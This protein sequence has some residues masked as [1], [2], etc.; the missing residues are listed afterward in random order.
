MRSLVLWSGYR[1]RVADD[2]RGTS[3]LRVGEPFLPVV[4]AAAALLALVVA[5][6]LLLGPGAARFDVGMA[7]DAPQ[8]V[9]AGSAIPVLPAPDRD[10]RAEAAAQEQAARA[11]ALAGATALVADRTAAVAARDATSWVDS[12]SDAATAAAEFAALVS[13]PVTA[14]EIRVVEEAVERDR[15]V[16]TGVGPGTWRGRAVTTYQLGSSLA[17]RR[18]DSFSLLPD[19]DGGWRLSGW[20]ASPQDGAT[21]P[22]QLGPV[23]HVEGPRAVVLSWPTAQEQTDTPGDLAAATE[24]A[25]QAASWTA[26]G[27]ELVDGV[28]GKDWPRT[29]LMLVPGTGSQ[30]SA[31]VPGEQP[32]VDNVYAAVTADTVT[33]SGTGD[34]V[35][36]NPAARSE[37][38][39]ETWQVTVTH[40]LV[41]VASGAVHGDGQPLWLSEG[42]ADL[43]GWSEVIDEPAERDLVAGRLLDRVL[44]GDG[45][46]SLAGQPEFTATDPEVVG[47]AYDGSWLAVLL[48]QDRLGRDGLMDLYAATSSGDGAPVD[49]APDDRTPEDR[50]PE[51]RF[52]AEL[53]A[54]A[55][56]DTAS[57]EALWLQ[58]LAGLAADSP[59]R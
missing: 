3:S 47:D 46:R 10:P 34:V 55:G 4:L 5:V 39:P 6:P 32:L 17:V 16:L 52:D 48:L 45:P 58:Y 27:S 56:L 1:S 2:Q 57:F 12:A 35:V 8:P 59:N 23:A 11:S 40:E 21:A 14:F 29:S 30:Y 26:T 25:A 51:D 43:V 44:A 7:G 54:R 38:Q 9:V 18:E 36:L 20:A 22:W 42:V 53:V 15:D 28:L 49:G 31:L 13:L 19:A 37:L 50:T 33:V 41:H 24:R